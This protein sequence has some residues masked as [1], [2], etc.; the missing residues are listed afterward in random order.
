MKLF[1]GRAAD[2]TDLETLWPRCGFASPEAAAGAF[3]AAY[4]HLEHDPHLAD[5]IRD[6]SGRT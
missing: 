1:A 2:T 4:P 3:H 6:L 5:W